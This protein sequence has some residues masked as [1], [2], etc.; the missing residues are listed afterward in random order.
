MFSCVAFEMELGIVEFSLFALA[1]NISNFA[2]S[3]IIS[4]MLPVKAFWPRNISLS[5]GEEPKFGIEPEKKFPS[6]L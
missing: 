3:P 5:R 1:L 6:K 4:G 2:K